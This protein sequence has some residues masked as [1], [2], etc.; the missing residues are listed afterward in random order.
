V[1]GGSD[2]ED[3]AMGQFLPVPTVEGDPC[4]V[5]GFGTQHHFKFNASGDGN[6][7]EGERMGTD[8]GDEDGLH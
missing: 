3:V 2:S 6:G 5:P 7:P 4:R 1:D 8:G